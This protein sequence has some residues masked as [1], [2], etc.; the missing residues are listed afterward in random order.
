MVAG[1]GVGLAGLALGAELHQRDGGGRAQHPGLDL[2]DGVPQ[3][4]DAAAESEPAQARNKCILGS[5]WTV[6]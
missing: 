1:V 6:K 3:A 5:V 4:T 2:G